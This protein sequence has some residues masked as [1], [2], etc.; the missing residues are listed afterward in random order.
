MVT[1]TVC[2]R[3]K[4]PIGRDSQDNGLCDSD[5]EGYNLLPRPGYNWPNEE[6]NEMPNQYEALHIVEAHLVDASKQIEPFTEKYEAHMIFAELHQLLK[7]VRAEL[8]HRTDE[9]NE[10]KF[11]SHRP[12][13]C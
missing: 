7:I 5:C 8:K 1:C 11:G 12:P 2:G 3:A 6:E 10:S 4:K 9:R 13:G